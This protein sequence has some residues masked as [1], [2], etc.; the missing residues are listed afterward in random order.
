MVNGKLSGA[1]QLICADFRS[2][3][4]LGLQIRPLLPPPAQ[5]LVDSGVLRRLRWLRNRIQ[6][7][8]EMDALL[9]AA[10]TPEEKHEAVVAFTLLTRRLTAM[11]K[12]HC[13]EC[14][15]PIQ[16]CVCRSIKSMNIRHNLFLFQHVG[17]FGRQ[18]NSGHLLRMI[19]GAERA[20]QGIRCEV[21]AMLEHAEEN[22]TSS[23]VL[24][25]TLNSITIDEF[26][27]QRAS[28]FGAEAVEGP[29]TLF[30]PDGTSSQAKNL[31]RHLPAYLP[32]VRINAEAT[33]SWLDPLRRQTEEHRVCTAQAAAL[34]LDELG[35][36]EA[37][38][39]VKEAVELVV[40]LTEEERK[41]FKRDCGELRG[42]GRT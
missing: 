36:H 27:A 1:A 24:F 19:F 29:L 39:R 30:L 32:R 25:P 3:A 28:R 20:T 42:L 10:R 11:K 37:M 15:Y 21:D 2:A 33:R 8:E 38:L 14:M 23:L 31:E 6:C 16:R 9:T 17:E 4:A 35:E 26:Q 5:R 13:I 22:R 41:A 12:G 18:N 34:V 7:K 40:R